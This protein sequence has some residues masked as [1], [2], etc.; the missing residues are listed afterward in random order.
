MVDDQS[1]C[2]PRGCST[3]AQSGCGPPSQSGCGPPAQSGCGP[4]G[5]ILQN[6]SNWK[7][8]GLAVCFRSWCSLL[9]VGS[10]RVRQVLHALERGST[11]AHTDQRK[12]S[13][14]R[15]PEA[16]RRVDAF[17]E[18]AYQH[19]AEPLA[20]ATIE[21]ADQRDDLLP[22]DVDDISVGMMEDMVVACLKDKP[23]KYLAP[24]SVR[25]L[26]DCYCQFERGDVASETS[27]RCTLNAWSGCL[28][29]R[30][31]SQHAKCT[32]CGKLQKLR[33]D[34]TN[35]QERKHYQKELEVH[36][37]GMFMDRAIDAR[38]GK[39]SEGGAHGT[40]VQSQGVLSI[41]MDGMDQAKFKCPRIKTITKDLEPLW[42]PVLHVTGCLAEGIGEYYYIADGDSKKT[43]TRLL[44]VFGPD[45]G[46]C[47][48][49]VQI[50]IAGCAAPLGGIDRQHS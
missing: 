6:Q 46:P 38:V 41:A 1:G 27:F 23:T 44:S 26:Y 28:K 31:R 25:D 45:L 5:S 15:D 35:E 10:G 16:Q 36:L 40:L 50:K 22:D 13:S 19:M 8:A 9:S 21:I 34:A 18:F 43:M 17:L 32:I 2:G 20:D 37:Q 7:L 48:S 4:P 49:C 12:H 3:D 39:L 33:K 42:R 11:G 14:G 24:G 30:R 47:G 29:F